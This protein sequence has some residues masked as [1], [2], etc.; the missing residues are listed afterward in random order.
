MMKIN[1]IFT[2]FICCLIIIFNY[3]NINVIATEVY[4]DYYDLGEVLPKI[5]SYISSQVDI[6]NNA[7]KI[8]LITIK[9]IDLESDDK[10]QRL[11][12]ILQSKFPQKNIFDI[13]IKT[14][15]MIIVPEENINFSGDDQQKYTQQ[16]IDF[17]NKLLELG[18]KNISIIDK[19]SNTKISSEYYKNIIYSVSK[20]YY[21]YFYL[22]D[23]YINHVNNTLFSNLE[24]ADVN[25]KDDVVGEFVAHKD[26]IILSPDLFK[27]QKNTSELIEQTI[28]H[29]M[30]H[31]IELS[32]CE[33]VFKDLNLNNISQKS[34]ERLALLYFC[35]TNQKFSSIIMD[36]ILEKMNAPKNITGIRDFVKDNLSHYANTN[37]SEFFAEA[38]VSGSFRDESKNK[39]ISKIFD[40]E[41]K[42]IVESKSETYKKLK[43]E[44][45][46]F[47]KN[48]N[49]IN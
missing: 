14:T 39:P 32:L 31:S 18:V 37:P 28:I 20:I 5:E 44:A 13:Y 45:V 1:K 47:L 8:I 3:I 15:G 19:K 2:S 33:K 6:N 17:K 10:Y 36:S 26:K 46:N 29:E 23:K 11:H 27:S 38:V 21:K 22:T 24:I 42:A 16:D 30:G 48:N 12:D 4:K 9:D 7:N 49:I 25:H 43:E 34:L 35:D 40:E 41:I